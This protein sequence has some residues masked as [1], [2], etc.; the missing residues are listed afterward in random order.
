MRGMLESRPDW[1]ISRQRSWGLPIPAFVCPMARAFMTEASVRA[2]ARRVP[3]RARTRGSPRSPRSCS[4]HYDPASDPAAPDGLDVALLKKGGD[5]LDV[6]F[7][8]GSSWNAVMRERLGARTSRSSCTSRARTS[9]AGGSSSRC[10]RRLGVMGRAALQDAADARVH[11]RQGRQEAEQELG[12]TIENLFEQVRGGRAALVGASSLAYENDVKVDDEFFARG[13]ELPQGP[14]HVR[15]L[16]SN[17]TTSRCGE[18]C[19]DLKSIDPKS[20]DAWALAEF[21]AV[22]PR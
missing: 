17:L 10:C 22:A 2:V 13:R 7:E 21:D 14:Q 11:G 12:H 5:I 19:V 18:D 8:S 15:F 16:L 4:R 6:W 20:I 3:R 1:C 9:T